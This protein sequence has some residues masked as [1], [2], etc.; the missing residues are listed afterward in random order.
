MKNIELENYWK[1]GFRYAFQL[2]Y[3]F[4]VFI[5]LI[6]SWNEYIV[7]GMSFF[8]LKDIVH[9]LILFFVLVLERL[10]TISKREGIIFFVYST[11]VSITVSLPFRVENPAFEFEPYFLKVEFILLVLTFLIGLMVHS[12]HM[13]VLGVLNL[14]FMAYCFVLT[15]IQYPLAKL[16][17][18][19]CFVSGANYIGYRLHDAYLKLSKELVETNARLKQ[20]Y[21]FKNDLLRIIGH[22]V[23]TPFVQLDGLLSVLDDKD[24]SDSERLFVKSSMR[25]TVSQG[26]FLLQNLVK[27]TQIEET[28]VQRHVEFVSLEECVRSS[29]N[30]F[31]PFIH[32]KSLQITLDLDTGIEVLAD[33]RILETICRNLISNAVK[34]SNKEGEVTI[35]AYE[36]NGVAVLA[37]VD[38]GVG[39]SEQQ[40]KSVL[41]R[42]IAKSVHGTNNEKGSGL[43]LAICYRLIDRMDGEI[44]LETELG[45]GSTFTVQFKKF[46]K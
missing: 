42:T 4:G 31:E 3:L 17:F 34:F 12:Y 24:L 13:I 1:Y 29:L 19:F 23:R 22:D 20:A 9:V 2:T 15:P 16:V 45:K 21:S 11:A 8:F 26:D 33:S 35:R 30:L 36:D 39:M 37:V 28:D 6:D 14:A 41:G 27:W 43:G 10:G 25:K 5:I 46:R 44:S 38:E 7:G 32:E 40:K 18:Y